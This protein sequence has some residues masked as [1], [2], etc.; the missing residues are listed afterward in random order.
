[1]AAD[2]TA[3]SGAPLEA[4]EHDWERAQALLF[5]T[6]R[7]VGT[8]GLRIDD[9]RPDTLAEHAA[10][11]HPQALVDEGPCGLP[12]VYSLNAGSFD[13]IVNADHLLA[14]GV[15]P[16]AIQDA[17]M[18]NLA[19]WSIDAPWTDE[20]SGDRRLLSSDTGDGCDAARMLL[21]EVREGEQPVDQAA[22]VLRVLADEAE[23]PM[24]LGR[25]RDEVVPRPVVIVAAMLLPSIGKKKFWVPHDE[26]DYPI[27]TG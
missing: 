22:H 5:P 16:T 26:R 9:L 27:L 12:V 18:R 24:R 2:P 21:P 7:P 17:A 19:A 6:F 15:E 23:I 14:W 25:E 3:P 1:M 20:V 4:P 8:Q 13:V 10:Q 11:Q